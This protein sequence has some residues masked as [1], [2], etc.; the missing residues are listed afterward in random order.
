MSITTF[1]IINIFTPSNEDCDKSAALLPSSAESIKF[2]SETVLHKGPTVSKLSDNGT[3][4]CNDNRPAV[5]FNPTRSFHALGTLTEP[6]V[7]DPIPQEAKLNATEA[8]APED[9]PPA[10]A[11]KLF[12]HGGL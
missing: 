4:P 2:A 8:A 6:P 9:E 1:S 10:T 5:V 7:S 12:M 11:S 3:T